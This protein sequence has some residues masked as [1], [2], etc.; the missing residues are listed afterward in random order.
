MKLKVL[1][2]LLGLAIILLVVFRGCNSTEVVVEES[3]ET[4][5]V[6]QMMNEIV[7]QQQQSEASP[8]PAPSAP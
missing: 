2:P 6:K 5:K 3:P 7:L 8:S 4:V 1:L